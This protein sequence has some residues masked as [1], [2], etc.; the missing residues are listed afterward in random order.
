MAQALRPVS[1]EFIAAVQYN[2]DV[3][4][5]RH[6]GDYALCSYLLKM[7]EFYRWH[8]GLPFDMVLPHA[9]I[10][11][12]VE[13]RE[14][15][16]ERLA[17]AEYRA[18][19]VGDREHDP[20]AA[21][22]INRILLSQGLV[23][24]AGYGRY[25]KPYFFLGALLN[26]EAPGDT[27]IFV[28]GAEY[29]RELVAAPAMAQGNDIFI[30]RESLKRMLWEKVEE[31]R[32]RRRDN[33]LARALGAYDFEHHADESLERMTDNE[34]DNAILHEIG[35][36]VA[37]GLLG[38][39][40]PEM[41]SDVSRTTAELKARAVRDHLADCLTSLPAMLEENNPASIH[42]YF[43]NLTPL[44]RE[45]FPTLDSAYQDFVKARELAPL[46]RAV[47]NGRGHWLWLSNRILGLWHD[48]GAHSAKPIERLVAESH[49]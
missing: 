30:R 13:R 3:S 42:F 21:E 31:W 47:R 28:S 11:A 44:R 17:D 35:E 9:E 46:K 34:M 7:R 5:A 49:F 20:F 39:D 33:A 22:D 15:L 1:T 19:P 24:S 23:Y 43:A 32:W 41:I 29:A 45:L 40:W 18:L 12:F 14:L 16:W 25:G 8:A 6:A 48:Q 37:G 36:V 38:A 10:G 27:R 2:C 26:L 4:D